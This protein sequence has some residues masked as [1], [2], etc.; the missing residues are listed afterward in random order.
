MY[1]HTCFGGFFSVISE[2]KGMQQ[3]VGFL[4][5]GKLLGRHAVGR[6]LNESWAWL[7]WI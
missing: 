2:V 1:I 4:L 5:V 6:V 3:I 7:P